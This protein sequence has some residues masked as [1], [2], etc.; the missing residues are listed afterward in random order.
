MLHSYD[1]SIHF[2]QNYVRVCV[3]LHEAVGVS[4]VV[5]GGGV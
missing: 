3:Y 2:I 4:M 1:L 5:D